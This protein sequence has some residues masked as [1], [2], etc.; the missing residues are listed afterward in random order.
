MRRLLSALLLHATA[1][2]ERG[3]AHDSLSRL[4]AAAEHMGPGAAQYA[5]EA[6]DNWGPEAAE[7]EARLP[8]RF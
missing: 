8:N 6:V 4:A 7:A 5:R 3:T 1:A 2:S